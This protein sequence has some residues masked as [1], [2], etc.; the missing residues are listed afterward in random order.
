MVRGD[1][2][3]GTRET[4]Q[5]RSQCG[6]QGSIG[7]LRGRETRRGCGEHAGLATVPAAL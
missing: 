4:P 7:R 1:R 3:E 5:L 2:S 6:P